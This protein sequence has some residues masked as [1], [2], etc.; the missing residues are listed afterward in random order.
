[1]SAGQDTGTTLKAEQY[2]FVVIGGGPSGST[3]AT[4][5]A[6]HGHSV[7][8]LEAARFPR[9]AVGELIAATSFWRVWNRLGITEE[10][11]DAQF[12]RKYGGIFEAPSGQQFEFNQDV[13]PEDPTCRPYVYNLERAKYDVLLLDNARQRG[14]SVLEEAFV[15]EV[16]QD[17]RGRAIGVRYRHADKVHEAHCNVVI[18]GSGRANVLARKLDLRMELSEMKSFSAFAHFEGGLRVP[19]RE[20]GH[21]RIIFQKNMWLW[22][23]PLQRPKTSIGLVANKDIYWDEYSA[24]PEAFFEKYLATFDFCTPRLAGAKRITGFRPVTSGGT[25][26]TAAVGYHYAAKELVGEGWALVGDAGGFVDPVFAAGLFAAQSSAIW[27]ADELH[28]ASQEGDFSCDRLKR[29]EQRFRDEF[30][31]L[32]FHVKNF[33]TEY[34]NPKWVDF[35]VSMGL[36]QPKIGQLYIDTFIANSKPSIEKYAK[37]MN[38][39]TVSM[40]KHE[41]SGTEAEAA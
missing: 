8:V 3:V 11:L 16:L 4:I 19:G 32:L 7:L 13:H 28:A 23:A 18:D 20:E 17:E 27:L 24:G 37:L 41:D 1:M 26:A 6:E 30:D 12:L 31:P 33:A 21:L 40:Q 36:R 38:R 22:W 5:L 29:Y 34:F 10:Q 15:D 39:L 2:D 35:F 9:F 25:G 14:A